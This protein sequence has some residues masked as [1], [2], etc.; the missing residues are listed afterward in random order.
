L[1]DAPEMTIPAQKLVVKLLSNIDPP[2]YFSNQALYA[3]IVVKMAQISLKYG[4][5][6]ESAK[7]YVTYGLI[8]GSVL[9]DY[10]SGYEFGQLAVQMSDK[11]N[12]PAQKCLF[13]YGW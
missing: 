4:H 5:V 12:N 13:G 7:A 6:P 2:A 3:V 9:G 8:L 10:R 11:F 1:L